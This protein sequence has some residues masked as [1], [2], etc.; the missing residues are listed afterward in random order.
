MKK[1]ILLTFI[2]MLALSV[3]AQEEHFKFL[4]IPLD[5]SIEEFEAKLCDKGFIREMESRESEINKRNYKGLFA[6][7]DSDVMVE[8]N[9]RDRNVYSDCVKIT[10]SDPKTILKL[11]EK[12][13]DDYLQK[14]PENN[15]YEID[16]EES[17]PSMAMWFND[18]SNKKVI[19]Q[20]TILALPT[21]YEIFRYCSLT[22]T[23]TDMANKE[24]NDNSK[25]DD[26]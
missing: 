24:K 23:Y 10:R 2:L 26:L 3:Y 12:F 16:L 22:I 21:M 14:Y 8:F 4:G 6:G 9:P 19:G 20:V 5:G 15:Y 7:Y 13:R 11:Y 25:L 1:G 17:V 18:S